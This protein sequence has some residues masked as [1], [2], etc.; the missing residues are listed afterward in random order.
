MNK[1]VSATGS[2]PFTNRVVSLRD[3]ADSRGS[4]RD[5]EG[6]A[7]RATQKTILGQAPH[8]HSLHQTYMQIQ[9]LRRLQGLRSLV[10]IMMVSG[11]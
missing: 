2:K 6:M 8:T 4:L 9:L 7:S 1:D 10:H 11:M 5:Y 3:G